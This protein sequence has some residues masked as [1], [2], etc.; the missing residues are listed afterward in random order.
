MDLPTFLWHYLIHQSF[1]IKHFS[2]SFSIFYS[3]LYYVPYSSNI[4]QYHS[5]FQ[6]N[7]LFST[8]N[9]FSQRRFKG[10]PNF[11]V[12][13]SNHTTRFSYKLFY[14]FLF[15]TTNSILLGLMPKG[16]PH[17]VLCSSLT[18]PCGP[19]KGRPFL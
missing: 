16:T 12:A 6:F 3:I 19:P 9:I 4:F 17:N 2:I 10:S 11:K 18:V 15:F 5:P 14:Y 1:F 7:P 13:Y 8:T